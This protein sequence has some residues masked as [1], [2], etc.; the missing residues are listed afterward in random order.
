[1][2]LSIGTVSLKLPGSLDAGAY[3]HVVGINCGG[4]SGTGADGAAYLADI[5][6]SG[7][8][9]AATALAIANT[10][11]DAIYQTERWGACTYSIP[12]TAGTYR[13]RV[14]LAEIYSLIT[15][16]GQRVFTIR[17]QPGLAAEQTFANIDQFAVA[18]ALAAT[19]IVADVVVAS[20]AEL[21][22]QMIAQVESP[23]VKAI[24]VQ[25]DAGGTYTPNAVITTPTA[26]AAESVVVRST[27]FLIPAEFVGIHAYTVP[28]DVRGYHSWGTATPPTFPYGIRRS[29]NYDGIFWA[30]IHK[31][32]NQANWD[33]QHLDAA[34]TH[35]Q[36]RGAQFMYA[37]LYTP[38]HLA[39]LPSFQSPS[40]SWPGSTSMP[41]NLTETAAFIT[42]MVTRY[43]SGGVR[44]LHA[45][46]VWN[47]P[48]I[49]GEDYLASLGV[50]P[51]WVGSV[52]GNGGSNRAAR[53][54][55][56]ALLHK[57]IAVAARNADPDIKIV[58]PGWSPGGNAVNASYW[59]AYYNRAISTGG[60]PLQYTDIL[61][62]HPYTGSGTSGSGATSA[63]MINA[64]T[65][66]YRTCANATN[67]ALPLWGTEAGNEGS[68]V[69]LAQHATIIKRKALLAAG[70]GMASVHWYAYEDSQYLGDPF[71]NAV[72]RAALAELTTKMTGRTMTRCA[73]LTDGTVWAAFSDGST[74]RE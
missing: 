39:T 26:P 49:D 65:S 25:S 19:E 29:L 8:N 22:V 34:I 72:P 24:V 30:D 52:A 67:P 64:V 17:F 36:S 28:F 23:A 54:D 71:T 5:H 21:V 42:A 12:V 51:Y 11:D 6:F 68:S 7:G 10:L 16:V 20:G 59:T 15:A 37:M 56:L 27:P 9:T 60:T 74:Y 35:T 38:P 18:G 63:T 40:P 73:I 61:S 50:L 3:A 2:A 43:N 46:E 1:M 47:E 70:A 53:L 58:G 31:G 62:C 44:R 55:D 57:T 48:A 32:S 14:L 66:A 33:W 45:I 13:V 41:N 4:L 69:T